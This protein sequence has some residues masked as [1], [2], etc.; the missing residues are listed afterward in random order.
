MRLYP[1]PVG[2]DVILTEDVDAQRTKSGV[3][4][5]KKMPV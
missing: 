1:F 4:S 2:G 5:E 3:S